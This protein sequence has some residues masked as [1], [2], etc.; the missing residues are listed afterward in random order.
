[1]WRLAPE[2]HWQGRTGPLYLWSYLGILGSS[3]L[4]CHRLSFSS[5]HY[6]TICL[7]FTFLTCIPLGPRF[8]FKILNTYQLHFTGIYIVNNTKG[9]G[10]HSFSF[11][12]ILFMK[13]NKILKKLYLIS[14]VSNKNN[15]FKEEKIY[16]LS[17]NFSAQLLNSCHWSLQPM[18]FD[19][20][21]LTFGVTFS[22][23]ILFNTWVGFFFYYMNIGVAGGGLCY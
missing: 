18:D 7:T 23:E 6:T 17:W 4:P 1:M 10:G 16:I 14:R 11:P 20:D 12:C 19:H 9:K 21:D 2:K 13:L 3:F 15:I 22:W 5:V 8:D